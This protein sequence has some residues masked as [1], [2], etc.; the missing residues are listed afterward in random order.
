MHAG[1]CASSIFLCHALP[2]LLNVLQ[3]TTARMPR[4]TSPCSSGGLFCCTGRNACMPEWHMEGQHEHHAHLGVPV[5]LVPIV[6]RSPAPAQVHDRR[7][8]GGVCAG[9]AWLRLCCC[10]AVLCDPVSF[11]SISGRFCPSLVLPVPL[12]HPAAPALAQVMGLIEL[13]SLKNTL[14][15]DPGSGLSVEQR[16]VRGRRSGD[17]GLLF[18]VRAVQHPAL[19]F[20]W[21]G[22]EGAQQWRLPPL[23]GCVHAL[24]LGHSTVLCCSA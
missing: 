19:G 24:I 14:V 16:K 4:C 23:A 9:G 7:S 3:T 1:W 10:A 12:L 11:L 20:G 5:H 15:G 17:T 22:G 18:A 21:A 2:S 8:R 13:T 6:Q